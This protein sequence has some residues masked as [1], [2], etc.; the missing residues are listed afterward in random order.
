[1]KEVCLSDLKHGQGCSISLLIFLI[2]KE[3]VVRKTL[4][5]PR[6]II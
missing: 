3:D 1:M 6:E 2:V 4:N 5:R